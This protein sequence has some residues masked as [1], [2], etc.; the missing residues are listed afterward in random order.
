[1]LVVL[2]DLRKVALRFF[3]TYI[4]VMQLASLEMTQFT[5]YILKCQRG[6]KYEL[7]HNARVR[8]IS[9]HVCRT[10]TSRLAGC[11]CK[12][13]YTWRQD[14]LLLERSIVLHVF[15]KCLS[16]KQCIT[17]ITFG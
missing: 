16:F 13:K 4:E 6:L 10:L 1:M 15:A 14:I 7:L 2:Q 3:L 11:G 9:E 5:V 12:L 8:S 17:E